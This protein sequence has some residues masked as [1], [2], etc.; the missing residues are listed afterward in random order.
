MNPALDLPWS[1]SPP[2]PESLSCSLCTAPVAVLMMSFGCHQH[3]A[4][5]ACTLR[6]WKVRP[7]P[8]PLHL[9]LPSIIIVT[10]AYLFGAQKGTCPECRATGP[11]HPVSVFQRDELEACLR[12]QTAAGATT[13][14]GSY[15]RLVTKAE[16]QSWS[17][18]L[19]PAL[20]S[21]LPDTSVSDSAVE[22]ART[23]GTAACPTAR[24][25]PGSLL[26]FVRAVCPSFLYEG[27]DQAR[28]S[29]F[30]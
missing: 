12:A 22:W 1:T 7:Q 25:I 10:P 24:L 19:S 21:P 3:W 23:T 18:Q 13:A 9:L 14:V 29:S 20:L 4:C 11:P 6:W 8:T 5:S 16:G 28:L 27:I 15:R 2:P 17:S 30:T 26:A